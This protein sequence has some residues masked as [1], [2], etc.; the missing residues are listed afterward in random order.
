[1]TEAREKAEK[2]DCDGIMIGRGVFGNPWFFSEQK[3]GL[4]YSQ[5]PAFVPTLKEKVEALDHLPSQTQDSSLEKEEIQWIL[6][7]INALVE[8]IKLFEEKLMKT[9]DKNY[10]VMKKHFKAYINDFSN[11]KEIRIKLME[12]ETPEQAIAILT[13]F[14]KTLK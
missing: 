13:R 11:A 1:M 3:P 14:Q 5:S 2:Y 6:L 12:T 10:D 8:H 9:G 7:K 4:G